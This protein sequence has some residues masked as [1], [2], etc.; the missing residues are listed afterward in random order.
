MA[1]YL[2]S[3]A[4]WNESES[5]TLV[6]EN[7]MEGVDGGQV[8]GYTNEVATVSTNAN[9]TRT[10]SESH[11]IDL[12]IIDDGTPATQAILTEWANTTGDLFQFKAAGYSDDTFLIWDTAVPMTIPRQFDAIMTRKVWLTLTA[13]SGYSGTQPL[14]KCPVYAGGNALAVYKCW[15]G[16]GNLLNGFL[17]TAGIDETNEASG[18]LEVTIDGTNTGYV[19]SQPLL[20]PFPEQRLTA[21]LNLTVDFAQGGYYLGLRFLD[22]TGAEI[23]V[24]T[25]QF[26]SA[27]TGRK[28]HTAVC[29]ALT[30][31]IQWYVRPTGIAGN[32]ITF[33]APAIRLGY[34]TAFT[35]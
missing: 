5:I 27:G 23:S 20:F 2:K 12:T 4:L 6:V 33:S 8:F 14:V 11:K 28:A 30:A 22:S 13:L 26:L 10:I 21:S 35:I 17:A 24:S 19:Y 31:F 25:T 7:I 18:A 16:N 1:L 9:Q 3:L 29:P 34:E 15:E 32:Y